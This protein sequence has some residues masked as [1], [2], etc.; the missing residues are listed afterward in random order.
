METGCSEGYKRTWGAESKKRKQDQ[1]HIPGV[2][3][4]LGFCE[5]S[6]GAANPICVEQSPSSI[7]VEEA[8]ALAL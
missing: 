6:G 3:S 5:G 4:A 2:T 8:V 1:H 7:V